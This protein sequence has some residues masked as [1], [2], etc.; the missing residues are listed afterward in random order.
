MF[1]TAK[2]LS[3]DDWFYCEFMGCFVLAGEIET[4]G[5]HVVVRIVG[6]PFAEVFHEDMVVCVTPPKLRPYYHPELN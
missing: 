5:P 6:L 2:Q 4:R 1:Q 3:S